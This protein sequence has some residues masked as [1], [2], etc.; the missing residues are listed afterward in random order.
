MLTLWWWFGICNYELYCENMLMN[1]CGRMH[2]IRIANDD[3]TLNWRWVLHEISVVNMIYVNE[4]IL[5]NVWDSCCEWKC[6]NKIM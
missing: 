2:E 3:M 1:W 6:D 4:L 5:K